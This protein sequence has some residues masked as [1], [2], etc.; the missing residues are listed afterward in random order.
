MT[1][2]R[3]AFVTS[4]ASCSVLPS[5]AFAGSAK[6]ITWD[7]LIPADLPYPEIIGQG[8]MD[9]VNDI[10][11]PQYDENGSKLN[12]ALDGALIKMPGYII[13][14]DLSSDGV[15]SFMLVPYVGACIHT[16]PP[17]ANQLVFVKTEKPWPSDNLWDPVWVTGRMQNKIQTTE[18]AEAGYMLTA[19]VME[20]YIW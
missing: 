14:I 19:E 8:F 17:P 3:R 11:R 6:E 16:P 13:P 15:T 2:S 10:W 7:D 5:A 12:T 18:I 9:E 20:P 4:I 1:L